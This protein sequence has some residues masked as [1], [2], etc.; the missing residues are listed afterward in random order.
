MYFRGL[1]LRGGMGRVW[2][3]ER[4]GEVKR[5]GGEERGELPP[6]GKSG[7][8][9]AKY[10]HE[11][12]VHHKT[13]ALRYY[14]LHKTANIND[15]TIDWSLHQTSD[16]ESSN[17]SLISRCSD[18]RLNRCQSCRWRAGFLSSC[19]AGGRSWRFLCICP[20]EC[21][22]FLRW[23]ARRSSISD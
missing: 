14:F 21:S 13:A 18:R 17:C 20:S 1:L 4:E 12:P 9:S 3:R 11:Y 16:V 6:T 2:G 10:R 15:K 19:S 7:S 22:K 5:R 23:S 8:A